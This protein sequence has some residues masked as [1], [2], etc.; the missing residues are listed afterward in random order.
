MD[1]FKWLWLADICEA[2]K[3]TSIIII[4]MCS[5]P[6]IVSIGIYLLCSKKYNKDT[7]PKYNILKAFKLCIFSLPICLLL[8]CVPPSRHTIY[9]SLGADTISNFADKAVNSTLG[10]KAVKLLESKIDEELK[11][12]Q[13][14]EKEQ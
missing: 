4:T 11:S 3:T 7:L 10:Q 14:T 9:I 13:L 2:V 5:I 6:G 1:I 12:T 8:I